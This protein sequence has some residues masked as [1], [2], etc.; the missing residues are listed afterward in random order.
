[1]KKILFMLLPLILFCGCAN[2]QGIIPPS[3]TPSGETTTEESE[4]IYMSFDLSVLGGEGNDGFIDFIKNP[5][6]AE[7]YPYRRII[8]RFEKREG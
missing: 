1:M 6:H 7:W 5:W 8:F 2:V 4:P 3:M